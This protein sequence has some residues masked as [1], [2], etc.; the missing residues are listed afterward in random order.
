MT[1]RQC[2][3]P[4]EEKVKHVSAK[5]RLVALLLALLIAPAAALAEPLTL[6]AASHF[7]I[8]AQIDG[9]AVRLRVDPEVSGYVTLNPDAAQRVGLRPSMIRTRM[10]IGPVRLTGFSKVAE[11]RIGATASNRRM[12]W[13][14]R[15]A[16]D[17][18]DGLIGPADLPYDRVTFRLGPDRPGARSVDV[19]LAFERG[20][21]LS[22]TAQ[23]GGQAVRVQFS[24]IQDRTRATAAAGSVIAAAHGGSWAGEVQER[25]IDFEVRRP[26]R[27]MAL[28][29]PWSVGPLALDA[30]LVR[31]QDN[32]GTEQ[33]PAD[34]SDPDEIVVTAVT[35][36]QRARYNVT[37]GRDWLD[38]CSSLVWD[39]GAR[40][41][42]MTCA[43]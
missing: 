25:L 2:Q 32:L 18:A 8:D 37:I 3:A 15:R 17:G 35:G 1:A 14:E 22:L 39:N 29:T 42:A 33:L 4:G 10:N 20:F 5:T 13:L 6:D 38:R 31:T 40:T 30:L 19:P 16:V 9:H 27:P 36:R 11:L 24:L 34:Q 43:P 26:V 7:T 21:G 41:M 23:V 28:A 12:V